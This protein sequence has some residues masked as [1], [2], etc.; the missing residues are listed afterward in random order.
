MND[1]KKKQKKLD[2]YKDF[3]RAYRE[4]KKEYDEYA[5][6]DERIYKKFWNE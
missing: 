2:N 5:E 4:G 3:C 1:E 6:R